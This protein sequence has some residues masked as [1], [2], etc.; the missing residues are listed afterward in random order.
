[1]GRWREKLARLAGA[2]WSRQ[3]GDRLDE[4]MAEHL[5]M[6]ADAYER[7][8]LSPAEARRAARL[9]FGNPAGAREAYAEQRGLPSLESF[10]NDIRYAA[11]V[12][13]RSPGFTVAAVLTLAVGIGVNTTIFTAVDAVALRPLPVK[14]GARLVRVERWLGS[15][16]RGDIQFAFSEPEF[17]YLSAQAAMFSD[18]VAARWLAAVDEGS[19]ARARVQFV[20]GNYFDALGMIPVAG[21]SLGVADGGEPG[22]ILSHAFWIRRFQGDRTI[23][24]R[25]LTLN[26]V[27]FTIAGVAP[28]SFIG[29]ANPPEIPDVWAPLS[30]EARM[31]VSRGMVRRFQIL[32]HVQPGLSRDGAQQRLTALV[33]SFDQAFPAPDAT[34]RLTLERASYF[35]ETNDPRFQSF[36]AA[37]MAVVGLVLL[38]ACAN[39]AN[40]LL[41]RGAARHREIAMRLALGASRPRIVRQLLTESTLLAMLGGAAGFGCSR[42]T[43]RLFWLLIANGVRL[44]AHGDVAPLAGLT[45]GLPVFVFTVAASMVAAAAFG[46]VPALRLSTPDLNMALKDERPLTGRGVAGV[47]MRRWFVAAQVAISMALLLAAGL[48][49]RGFAASRTATTGYDTSRVFDVEYPRGEDPAHARQVQARMRAALAEVDGLAVMLA[50]RLP[51]AGTWTPPMVSTGAA[52]PVA[53]RTLA[54]RV[55][56]EYFETL[57]VPIVRGRNFRPDEAGANVAIVSEATARQFWPGEDPLGRAFTLDMNFRGKLET[58]Q[59]VGIARDVRTASLSRIDPSFVYLTLVPS[60]FDHVI[61]RAAMPPRQ[62]LPAIRRT[63]AS[64]DAR[65]LNEL[66]VTSLDEGPLRLWH[67]MIDTLASFAGTLA[68]IA[69]ALA[70]AGI[71]GVVAYLASLRHYEIGVRL[72]LGATRGHILRLVVADAMAPVVLGAVA[73]LGGALMVSALLRSSLS[74]PSTPDVLFGVSAFDLATFVGVTALVAAAAAAASAGPLWRATRVD[75]LVA[76]RQS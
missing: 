59:V 15:E 44:F 30:A 31:G 14:D 9:D 74:F 6:L 18:V 25:T 71:Y 65:L 7:R 76:L 49:L 63:V 66:Q 8:G 38:I 33:A 22:V 75:P 47:A 12:L 4:E 45:P 72:A 19:G 61:V 3:Q 20:S 43:A 48:L 21:G 64:I 34:T 40:M 29:T 11:R 5:R 54:N 69:L 10:F 26:G 46:V 23:P 1:M 55:A 56:P 58:F 24:G 60:G 68:V 73:G 41:A 70:L 42:W 37:I 35:G 36:V 50:D 28:E 57:G 17:R 13:R 2:I 51:L 39:L 16:G 52:G 32:A 27:P 67:A 53:A 62:A